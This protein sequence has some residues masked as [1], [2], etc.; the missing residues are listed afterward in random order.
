MQPKPFLL[1]VLLCI[2][3]ATSA[4]DRIYPTRRGLIE[5]KVM[6]VTRGRIIYRIHEDSAGRDYAIDWDDVYKVEYADGKVDYRNQRPDR[7]RVPKVYT[8]SNI[9]SAAIFNIGDEGLGFGFAYERKLDKDAYFSLYLPVTFVFATPNEGGGGANA[10]QG[11]N[12][13]VYQISPALKLYPT[14]NNGKVRYAVGPQLNYEGGEKFVERKVITQEEDYFITEKNTVQ[15]LGLMVNNS[16]NAYPNQHIYLG[17]DVGMGATF[18]N[19]LSG[20]GDGARYLIQFNFRIG[21]RF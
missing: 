19:R 1:F 9:I 14:R 17:A 5:A 2:S 13:S 21:Y 18:I 15:Q 12:K 4:Q 7:N 11:S 3:L 16:L 20:I 8:G 10:A 6:E